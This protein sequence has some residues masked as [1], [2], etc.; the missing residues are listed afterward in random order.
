M[1]VVETANAPKPMGPYSQGIIANGFVFVCGSV[2]VDPKSG[3]LVKGGIVEQTKQALSNVRAIL[4]ASG[5]S[6]DKVVKVSVFLSDVSYGKDM[7]EVYVTYFTGHRPVRSTVVAGFT[8]PNILIEVDAIA[9][10]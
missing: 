2:G 4:E 1:K 8:N 5:S 10:Q 6:L 3:E 9:T 7:N